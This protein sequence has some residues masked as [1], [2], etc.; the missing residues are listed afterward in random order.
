MTPRID[1]HQ[2]YW[3]IGDRAGCWP[4]P[5]LNAIHRDFGPADLAPELDAARISGTVLVQSLPTEND[6]RF[7]LDL[8]ARTPTVCAVVGWVD[9]KAADAATKIAA[10]A[11]H[12][13][14]RGLRPML[15]DL[16][17]DAWIDDRILDGAVAAMIDHDLRFDA[18]VTPRHLD[19][20]YEFARRYPDL[21]IVVDHGAK[22]H[23]ATKEVEPWLSAMTR[24][25]LLP[26]VHCKLSGLWTEA[27]GVAD[28]DAL[29]SSVRPYVRAVTELFGARRLMWG[30]DWPVL[31]LAS[32]SGGYGAWLAA[33]EDD[34]TRFLGADAVP[35]V[36]GG[37]AY[38][39]YRVG[40]TLR[41][42]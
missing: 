10:F 14:A 1:A 4:P 5:E 39:F 7:L 23:I 31:R 24:L 21:R 16:P 30:S 34:C 12:P 37:N 13:K 35:A 40:D 8:A 2:H 27:G 28:E 26:N 17:D 29:R 15:Q 42:A 32:G 25:A 9:M 36:F 18:L 33:C 20:L 11:A 19:A 22:P 38:M 6:T 3:Q 41:R